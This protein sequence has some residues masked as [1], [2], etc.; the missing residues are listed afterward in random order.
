MRHELHLARSGF[1]ALAAV[2]LVSAVVGAVVGGSAGALSALIGVGLI[3]A[4][5]AVAVASTS[6]SR[7]VSANMM[8]VGFSM[9]VV[10]MLLVLGVFGTLKTVPWIHGAVLAG[11][12]C[13]ALVASL[14][15]ECVSYARGSYVP[16]W[17]TR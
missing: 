16:S 3:S 11:A 6:W 10:R 8:A 12:F 2:A 13:A 14:A 4:N 7:T 9:F 15:A 5:H 1:A 17:R